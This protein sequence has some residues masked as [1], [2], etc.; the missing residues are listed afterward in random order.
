MIEL[1]KSWKMC[2]CLWKVMIL[3]TSFPDV[4]FA[5]FAARTFQ[6]GTRPGQWLSDVLLRSLAIVIAQKMRGCPADLRA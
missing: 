6:A 1:Q 2:F 3:V 5:A 4:G